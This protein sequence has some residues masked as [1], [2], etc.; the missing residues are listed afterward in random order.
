VGA[1]RTAARQ[2]REN[3][4]HGEAP[5]LLRDALELAEKMSETDGGTRVREI[6]EEMRRPVLVRRVAAKVSVG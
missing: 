6:R 5:Q 4:A 3:S 2:A 1:L